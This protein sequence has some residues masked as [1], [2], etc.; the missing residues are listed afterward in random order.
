MPRSVFPI[1]REGGGMT[2]SLHQFIY[3][4]DVQGSSTFTVI[5]IFDLNCSRHVNLVENS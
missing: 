3:V 2:A 1:R 5:Y 4:R